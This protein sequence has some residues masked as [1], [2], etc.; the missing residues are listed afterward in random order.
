MQLGAFAHQ[1]VPSV[2]L[3]ACFAC[4]AG[5]WHIMCAFGLGFA[6]VGVVCASTCHYRGSSGANEHCEFMF[7]RGTCSDDGVYSLLRHRG[8]RIVPTS[9][10]PRPAASHASAMP[11]RYGRRSC[12]ATFSSGL[13]PLARVDLPGVLKAQLVAAPAR[14][15]PTPAGQ[16]QADADA[17][18][19]G[20]P[21]PAGRQ[22]CIM[23][24]GE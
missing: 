13:C 20:D 15:G 7:R 8:M 21:Q 1:T 22:R 24:L 14:L 19:R 23:C 10:K 16:G 17:G 11:R 9:S 2:C 3:P 18:V 12:F 5:M 6:R 4:S